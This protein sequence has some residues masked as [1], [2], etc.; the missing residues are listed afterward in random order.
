[1]T[2]FACAAAS[3]WAQYRVDTRYTG[4]NQQVN[5]RANTQLYGSSGVGGSVRYAGRQ[6]TSEPM[7]S[8]WRHAYW[9]S[10]ATPSDIRM[11]YAALGPLD[12]RGPMAYIPQKPAY[13]QRSGVAAPPPPSTT[14]PKTYSTGS[15]RYS[16]PR[17][18]EV[19]A[20]S[21]AKPVSSPRVSSTL[22]PAGAYNGRQYTTSSVRYAR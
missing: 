13:T 14:L 2:T 20:A 12:P 3:V 15:V 11:G 4:V 17:P 10:G 1:M 9:K 7:N 16:S 8:E 19:R 22:A 21:T 5:T 6:G 18:N